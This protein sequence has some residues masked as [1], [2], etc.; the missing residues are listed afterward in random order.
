MP[1][2]AGAKDLMLAELATVVTYLSAHTGPPGSTGAS[3]VTGGTYVRQPV[4]WG[5]P[6]GGAMAIT[7]SVTFDIPASTTVV[8][9]GL[10]SAETGGTFY[11]YYDCPDES[12]AAAGT[13]QITAGRTNGNIVVS[14]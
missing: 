6:S 9:I 12:F 10:W 1:F 14:A 4:T 3:E 11:G 5:T 7:A 8:A 13:W 2:T